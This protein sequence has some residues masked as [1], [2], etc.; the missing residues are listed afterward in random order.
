M[1]RSWAGAAAA[2]SLLAARAAAQ[3]STD[4]CFPP[5]N[6]NEARA[7]AIF[8]VPLAFSAA[9]APERQPAGR[10]RVGIELSLVPNVDRATATPTICRPGKGPE[11]TDL[12]TLAPRPRLSYTLPSGF[13]FEATWTPPVRISEV[14]A[15]LVGIAVSRTMALNARGAAVMLR[16]HGV[17]GEIKAPITCD[18]AA[19]QDVSSECYRGTRSDDSFHPNIIGIEAAVGWRLGASIRPY[20]GA[21]YNH[22][23]P[24]FRVNFTNQ[25]GQVDRRRVTVDLDRAVLFAGATWS[26]TQAFELSGEIYAAPADA[27]TARVAARIKLGH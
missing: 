12:L 5:K 18:D 10:A 3:G 15:N 22:L 6:S 21:G 14:R 2:L 26:A 20:L 23:A 7:M 27:V 1:I 25:F 11:H 13:S 4:D 16:A 17:F 8:D 9:A 19:L 24:R